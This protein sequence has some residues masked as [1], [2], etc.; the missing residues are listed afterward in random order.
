MI[1]LHGN[2]VDVDKLHFYPGLSIPL[3][4]LIQLSFLDDSA[5]CF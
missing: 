2:F 5:A 4:L 3:M 1:E